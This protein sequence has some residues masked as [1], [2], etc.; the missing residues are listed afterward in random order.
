MGFD[1]QAR[2]EGENGYELEETEVVKSLPSSVCI[3]GDV[4]RL[5]IE[6]Q[7]E[8]STRTRGSSANHIACI[9]R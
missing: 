6:K 9:C 5:M 2:L 1:V 8:V 7:L 3:G 4:A